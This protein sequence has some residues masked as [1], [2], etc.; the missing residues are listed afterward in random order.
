MPKAR[1]K[2]LEIAYSLRG[3]GEPLV[4]VAGFTQTKETWGPVVSH[5]TRHF[6]V[7][8]FDNRGVGE[9]TFPAGNFTIADMAQ[10]TVE[11]MDALGIDNAYFF[12]VSMGG[13]ITQTILLD[14]PQRVRKAALGCT[15][16][17]GRHAVQPAPEVMAGLSSMTDPNVAPRERMLRALPILYSDDFIRQQPERVEEFQEV[18]ARYLPHPAGASAQFQALSYFN[19]KKRLSEIRQPVLVITGDQDRMMPPENS[20][21]LAAG[22]AGAKLQ[23]VEGAGHS[24]FH[25]QPQQVARALIEF[26][27]DP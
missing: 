16:H 8:T 23:L 5:L 12:G 11:L 7:L 15:S 17:G 26:F 6:Q 4:M 1:V 14:R 25:E 24:F 10:D 22:I 20:R 3:S 9:T 21:L 18:A 13:L 2:E 27:S 19:V